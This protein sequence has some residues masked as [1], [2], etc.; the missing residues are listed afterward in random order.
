MQLRNKSQN[1]FFQKQTHCWKWM[2]GATAATAAGVTASQAGMITINLVNNYI[3]GPSGNHLNADLTGDGK[4]DIIIAQAFNSYITDFSFFGGFNGFNA[5]QG[6]GV[7]LNGVYAHALASPYPLLGAGL[8]SQY[9]GWNPLSGTYPLSLTGSIAV[10]FKDLHIN[11]GALTK[12]SLEVTVLAG[13]S[14]LGSGTKVQLDNL[15]FN[16]PDQGPS[17][18]LLAMGASGVLALRRWRATRKTSSG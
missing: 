7:H 2:T 9:R 14:P 1:V 18:A 6:A 15:S 8:G 13:F 17:L 11:N 16:V 10:S 4:P 5:I 3:S 12:G